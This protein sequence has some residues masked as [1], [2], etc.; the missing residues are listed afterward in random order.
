LGGFPCAET[1]NSYWDSSCSPATPGE[2]EIKKHKYSRAK[3]EEGAR[4]MRAFERAK[5][6]RLILIDLEARVKLLDWRINTEETCSSGSRIHVKLLQEY[7]E[8][9]RAH[10][11]QNTPACTTS[12]IE[13][14]AA[15]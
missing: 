13:T 15:L 4:E 14:I 10:N 11:M 7:R 9:V 8:A 2:E 6:W 5:P 12:C 3:F 1:P